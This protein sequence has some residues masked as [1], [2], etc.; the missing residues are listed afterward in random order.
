MSPCQQ[1][2]TQRPTSQA[3]CDPWA[4]A[5]TTVAVSNATQ[6]EALNPNAPQSR[7]RSDVKKT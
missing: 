2:Q 5:S 1:L 3:P 4:A 6:R 7:T